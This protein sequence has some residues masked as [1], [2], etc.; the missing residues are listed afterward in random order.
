MTHND[1][2][3]LFSAGKN[4]GTVNG[5][6]YFVCRPRH[7]IFVRVDKLIL[8]KRGRGMKSRQYN[9]TTLGYS[10]SKTEGLSSSL[11]D[12]NF[13][14]CSRPPGR[15]RGEPSYFLP[16]VCFRRLHI[17]ITHLVL[18]SVLIRPRRY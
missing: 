2:P 3:F 18:M 16:V 4:D 13:D 7:G 14:I 12:M 1:L 11:I 5:V 17:S 8:D 10:R 9:A 6:R 15:G